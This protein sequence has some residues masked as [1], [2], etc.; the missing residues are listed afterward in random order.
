MTVEEVDR[1]ILILV[2]T[3]TFFL[4][5]QFL[6]KILVRELLLSNK[7][8]SEFLFKIA[9]VALTTLLLVLFLVEFTLLFG[10]CALFDLI[11]TVRVTYFFL[12]FLLGLLVF[13]ACLLGESRILEELVVIILLAFLMLVLATAASFLLGELL[14]L[15]SFAR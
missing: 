12:L 10:F 13:L 5:K 14:F 9:T 15:L 7:I 2:S 8:S 4:P 3:A 11:L 1:R 6:F